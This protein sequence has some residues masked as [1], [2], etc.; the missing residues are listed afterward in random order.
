[1]NVRHHSHWREENPLWGGSALLWEGICCSVTEHL[2]GTSHFTSMRR[3]Q[4]ILKVPVS[5][6]PSP[7]RVEIIWRRRNSRCPVTKPGMLLPGLSLW[8]K[9]LYN[10][11]T[12]ACF[13]TLPSYK[14]L[15]RCTYGLDPSE[16]WIYYA[17]QQ[18][19]R[20]K[21]ST[22]ITRSTLSGPV[23]CNCRQ[24]AWLRDFLSHSLQLRGQKQVIVKA[25]FYNSLIF[26]GARDQQK[27]KKKKGCYSTD[28]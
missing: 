19:T 9:P 11:V 27:K 7:H 28:F 10:S 4:K 21:F 5:M 12:S 20:S 18:P 22:T 24:G 6:G 1:M 26:L 14:F 3:C 17:S 23:N 16:L 8:W 15:M 25:K 13:P 2:L